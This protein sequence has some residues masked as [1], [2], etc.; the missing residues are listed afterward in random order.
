MNSLNFRLKM[1]E[2]LFKIGQAFDPIICDN[3]IM[4]QV[5]RN[6]ISLQIKRNK[7]GQA[8]DT[9]IRNNFITI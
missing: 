2:Y 9:I 4:Q 6:N 1:Y 5:K 8:L 3:F 7:I